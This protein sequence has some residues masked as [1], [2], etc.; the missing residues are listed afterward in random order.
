[1]RNAQIQMDLLSDDRDPIGTL[2][3]ALARER[4]QENQQKMNSTNTYNT[5]TNPIGTSKVHYVHRNNNQQRTGLVPT[6]KTN[7]IP[8]WWK[9]GHKFIPGH[10]NTCPAKQE[11][12][13]ICKKIGHYAKMCKEEMPPRAL[14]RPQ[15]RNFAQNRNQQNPYQ[16]NNNNQNNTRKVRNINTTPEE[17]TSQEGST[18]S[19]EDGP[20]YPESTCYIREMIEDWNTINQQNQ[21]IQHW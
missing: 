1:M 9:C 20:V 3:Y 13:R 14:Q 2:Q 19:R 15:N 7:A 12:C 17:K 18:H 4:V 8:D 21:Q 16:Y 11:I 5:D 10:L 6:P